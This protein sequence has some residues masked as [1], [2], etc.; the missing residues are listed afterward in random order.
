MKN[1]VDLVVVQ[2]VLEVLI[3]SVIV[4]IVIESGVV[5]GIYVC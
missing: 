1:P 2:G 4:K 3:L 5:D